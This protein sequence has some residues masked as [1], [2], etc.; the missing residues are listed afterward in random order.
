MMMMAMPDD[1][2]DDGD[3][4]GLGQLQSSPPHDSFARCLS[5]HLI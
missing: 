3:G 4:P 1:N 5:L 2:D